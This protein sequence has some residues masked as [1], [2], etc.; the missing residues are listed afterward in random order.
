MKHIPQII[1]MILNAE[2][3][4]SI[5]GFFEPS[6]SVFVAVLTQAELGPRSKLSL[7]SFG[8]S[9]SLSGVL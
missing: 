6:E 9:R 5:L 7:V 4:Y 3:V 8:I 1:I 2:T